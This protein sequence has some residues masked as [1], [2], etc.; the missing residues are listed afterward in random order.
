MTANAKTNGTLWK[1][2]PASAAMC[3]LAIFAFSA[4]IIPAVLMRAAHDFVIRPELLATVIAVQFVGFFAASVGGGI[5][6]D[7]FGKKL[8][9]RAA[10]L[11]M[12]TGALL[13]A[14]AQRLEVIF[15]GSFVMGMA[16]GVLESM[17]SALLSDLFPHKRKM[18]L[19]LSQLVYCLAA[20]GG[21]FLMGKFLPEGT[22]WRVF[23]SALAALPCMLFVL[24]SLSHIPHLHDEERISLL[25]LKQ[26]IRR[27]SF[28]NPCVLIF[29]YVFS[30]ATCAVFMNYYLRT[31]YHAPE[32]WAIYSITIFWVSMAA[33]RILCACIPEEFSYRNIITIL[34]VA[35]GLAMASQ[36]FIRTWQMSIVFFTFVGF[37]QAGTWPLIIGM[38]ATHNRS[39]SGTVVGITV[40]CGALGMVVAPPVMSILFGVLAAPL[41]FAVVALPLF[42][43]SILVRYQSEP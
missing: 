27:W 42:A 25:E 17:S 15:L 41:V 36:V 33:G 23:F 34:M 5:A 24:Y 7:R 26:I 32:Q 16:G 19:N 2:L 38:T 21:P 12:A 37:L 14:T 28:L 35:S 9:L 31:H 22:S 30:E 13:W 29:L 43:G 11:L 40:A 18:F 6:A 3:A 1:V 39:Y 8:L 10:C 4:S 20:A